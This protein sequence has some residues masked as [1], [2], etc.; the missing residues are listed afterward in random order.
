MPR[1]QNPLQ[2]SGLF[3]RELIT[4]RV[5]PISRPSGTR[6]AWLAGPG[7]AVTP[8]R[9]DGD[10]S[11]GGAGRDVTSRARLTARR[12]GV[13]CRRPLEQ[14]HVT[15]SMWA[16]LLVRSESPRGKEPRRCWVIYGGCHFAVALP[17]GHLRGKVWCGAG[18]DY[19][20]EPRGR[21]VYARFCDWFP[22]NF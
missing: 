14:G 17:P 22:L 11:Y 1:K 6:S 5:P 13:R 10:G 19:G 18:F 2:F 20:R 21:A 3:P 9:T 16:P 7:A 12:N 15:M 8:S 4:P